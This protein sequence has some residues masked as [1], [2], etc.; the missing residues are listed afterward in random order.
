[1]PDD[2]PALPWLALAL[3]MLG[4]AGFAAAWILLAA[5]RDSQL[6]WMAVLAALDAA[7]LLRLGRMRGGMP[8]ALLAVLATAVAIVLANWGIA[9]AQIGR[10][11]GLLPWESAMRLGLDYAWNLVVLANGPV[12]LAWFAVALV[13][14]ALASR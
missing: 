5:S 3:I 13:A 4:T 11:L 10:M 12:D 8:R 7:M 1:M 9:A 2:R 6:S 14:A